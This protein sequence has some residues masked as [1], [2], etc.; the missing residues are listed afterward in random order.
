[1]RE[2]IKDASGRT[3]GYQQHVN[4]HMETI[5]DSAG[6]LLGWFDPNTRK[7]HDR[8]GKVVAS[9]GDVRASLIPKAKN[10]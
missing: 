10:R 6:S 4:D 3:L 2:I 8:S 9:G 1:M 5:T 7:T